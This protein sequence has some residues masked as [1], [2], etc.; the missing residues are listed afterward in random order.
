MRLDCL[1]S[2]IFPREF[3]STEVVTLLDRDGLVESESGGGEDGGELSDGCVAAK[4]GPRK[5]S[6]GDCACAVF[7]QDKKPRAIAAQVV[8][9]KREIV[10][11]DTEHL[12]KPFKSV[13]TDE[14][15]ST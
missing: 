4:I 7:P 1:T 3:A 5:S 10:Q 11:R 9:A 14:W 15:T 2:A 12:M 13:T 8:R 6:Y